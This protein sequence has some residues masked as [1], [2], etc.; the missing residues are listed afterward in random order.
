MDEIWKDIEGYE[1]YY[2]VSNYGRVK[3]L[4]V[5]TNLHGKGYTRK[6]KI[7]KLSETKPNS[8]LIV[9]LTKNGK[10][11]TFLVHRLVARAFVEN[12][13][14][15]IFDCVNHKDENK[16]NN[17]ADNLEWCDRKYNDN[18]GSRN[19]RL[20]VATSEWN[21]LHLDELIERGKRAWQDGKNSGFTGRKH[22]IA[23]KNKIS[24]SLKN[25]YKEGRIK[26]S[27]LGVHRYGKDAPRYGARL[28]EETKR[29]ISASLKGFKHTEETKQKLSKNVRGRVFMNNGIQNK[30]VKKEEI[31]KYLEEGYVL[32]RLTPW[33]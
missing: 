14:P 24:N 32:G 13:N 15:D 1:G 18:Y 20:S 3:Q 10:R 4:E 9:G 30:R 33:Q 26:P 7:K 31:S 12:Y 5:Y 8:Y 11:E 29:K 6:E 16:Q 21:N 19:L 25:G 27:M 17:C 2:Q 28:S 22:S 23:S